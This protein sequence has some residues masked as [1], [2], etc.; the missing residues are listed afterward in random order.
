MD[1]DPVYWFESF[2]KLEFDRFYLFYNCRNI[3]RFKM[4]YRMF[5]LYIEDINVIYDKI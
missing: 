1:I 4:V 3:V 2:M 5:R